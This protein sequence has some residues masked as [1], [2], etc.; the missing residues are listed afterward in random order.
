M[1][2]LTWNHSGNFYIIVGKATI[3]VSPSNYST[4]KEYSWTSIVKLYWI[5]VHYKLKRS[6]VFLY[7]HILFVFTWNHEE[8][9]QRNQDKD[10]KATGNKLWILR[11]GTSEI[12]LKHFRLIKMH[13]MVWKAKLNLSRRYEVSDADTWNKITLKDETKM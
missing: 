3:V 5:K 9:F 6:S 13:R 11:S 1:N 8:N 10:S 7:N 12:L 2:I 4:I